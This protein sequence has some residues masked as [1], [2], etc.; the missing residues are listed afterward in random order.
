MISPGRKRG[1]QDVEPKSAGLTLTLARVARYRFA[2]ILGL[3]VVAAFA[4]GG[5]QLYSSTRQWLA[6]DKCLD[7]GG[8]WSRS[9]QTCER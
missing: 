1:V 2:A 9:S 3:A 6:Q 5:W 4:A 8:R 7:S